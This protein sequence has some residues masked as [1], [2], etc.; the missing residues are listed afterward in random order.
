MILELDQIDLSSNLKKNISIRIEEG[1]A[2]I[3]QCVQS[4]S[5][6]SIHN[7]KTECFADIQN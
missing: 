2:L 4:A 3:N 5:F 7:T 6:I 1:E